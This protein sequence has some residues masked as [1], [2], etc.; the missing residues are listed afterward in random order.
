RRAKPDRV[1]VKRVNHLRIFTHRFHGS[2]HRVSSQNTGLIHALAEAHNPHL[3]RHIRLDAVADITDQQT[4]G[5]RSTINR[6]DPLRHASFR[7]HCLPASSAAQPVPR[8][9]SPTRRKASSPSGLVP[10]P[11]ARLWATNT[12]KH[13][14][15]DGMP[16]AVIPAIS[17]TTATASRS[18]RY[19][20]W[21]RW[22]ESA[23]S[24]DRK[25][26]RL[27]SSHVSI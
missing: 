25:S 16:P 27:N 26:T 12:C 6:R 2:L 10:G 8:H 11:R 21:A 4:D 13:L 15:R 7:Y 20:S 22:Y 5:I 14:T 19:A 1:H 24:G 17:G 18:A 9:H 3:T 23:S